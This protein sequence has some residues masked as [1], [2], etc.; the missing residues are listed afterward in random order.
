[1]RAVETDRIVARLQCAAGGDRGSN[2]RGTGIGCHRRHAR[3][4]D[5]EQRLPGRAG[6]IDAERLPVVEADRNR[7]S[8]LAESCPRLADIAV[9]ELRQACEFAAELGGRQLNRCAIGAH[10]LDIQLAGVEFIADQ[11]ELRKIVAHYQRFTPRRGDRDRAIGT[12]GGIGAHDCIQIAQQLVALVVEIVRGRQRGMCIAKPLIERRQRLQRVVR[13]V[14]LGRHL[15]MRRRGKLLHL[16][17]DLGSTAGEGR[18]LRE[19]RAARRRIGRMRGHIGKRRHQRVISRSHA[20]FR[21]AEQIIEPVQAITAGRVLRSAGAVRIRLAHQELVVDPLN[22]GNIDTLANE[23]R[24]PV[25]AS[26][27]QDGFT[28]HI[29]GRRGVG[30]VLA[31]GLQLDRCC[32]QC[33]AADPQEITHRRLRNIRLSLDAAPAPE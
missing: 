12:D 18:D 28:A 27:L 1:M 3:R 9:G 30:N 5:P 22:L 2:L 23:A 8:N 17:V 7:S 20:G 11:L 24:E 25:I 6:G 14:D 13:L 31:G 21:I 10:H 4:S 33:T 15:S 26:L 16:S 32:I 29:A 19:D